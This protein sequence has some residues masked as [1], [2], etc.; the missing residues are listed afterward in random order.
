M[1]PK[2]S[3]SIIDNGLAGYLNQLFPGVPVYNS[4]HQQKTDLP[5]FFIQH[6]PNSGIKKEI[7]APYKRKL[8]IDLVYMEEYNLTGL[9]EKYCEIAEMLDANLEL[10]PITQDSETFYMRTLDR[11]WE[12]ELAALHY[13]FH[14]EFRTSLTKAEQDRMSIIQQL[15]I[16]LRSK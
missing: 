16:H 1:K 4:P 9:E 15:N 3:V 5:S 11:T 7:G 13:K 14:L 12:V 2:I 10:F 6:M 8:F